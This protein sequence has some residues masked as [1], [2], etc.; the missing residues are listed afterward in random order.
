MA[1]KKNNIEVDITKLSVEDL[2][3]MNLDDILVYI[4][5]V[6]DPKEINIFLIKI[7]K[8]LKEITDESDSNH[9]LTKFRSSFRDITDLEAKLDEIYSFIEENY[10]LLDLELDVIKNRI[11][12]KLERLRFTDL[13]KIKELNDKGQKIPY[14]TALREY[15]SAKE[16]IRDFFSKICTLY[17]NTMQELDDQRR[18]LEDS[19]IL[20]NRLEEHPE[21]V[22]AVNMGTPIEQQMQ[23]LLR[24]ARLL[25]RE[26]TLEKTRNINA[27]KGKVFRE[28]TE[29]LK[30]DMGLI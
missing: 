6:K 21:F 19:I 11:E 2:K 3:Q 18:A 22:S 1:K 12:I 27:E 7:I 8:Q 4:N 28:E 30:K 16:V 13:I 10:L 24:R 23:E 15:N 26:K 20:L 25:D 5:E 29:K 9:S 17:T 14:E